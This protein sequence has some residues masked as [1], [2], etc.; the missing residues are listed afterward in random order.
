MCD[1]R[2]S[3][4]IE[5][6]WVFLWPT[7]KLEKCRKLKIQTTNSKALLTTQN[8]KNGL[9]SLWWGGGNLKNQWLKN[10]KEQTHEILTPL[11]STCQRCPY[12]LMGTR[13]CKQQRQ[14][15]H[16]QAGRILD[17]RW[18]VLEI[19]WGRKGP[20]KPLERSGKGSSSER[21]VHSTHPRSTTRAVG[22]SF[23]LPIVGDSPF[24]LLR[25]EGFLPF[26]SQGLEFPL[27]LPSIWVSP[28]HPFE[29]CGYFP[30][31][32]PKAVSHP[33]VLLR[34]GVSP[35]ILLRVKVPCFVLTR[36]GC[37]PLHPTKG[38]G[39]TPTFKDLKWTSCP[40]KGWGSHP[41]SCWWLWVSPFIFPRAR[42]TP[43]FSTENWGFPPFLFPKAGDFPL[44]SRGLVV[45]LWVLWRAGNLNAPE[46]L[47]SPISVL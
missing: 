20:S 23:I 4:Q 15:C 32:F 41:L 27:F 25:A 39:Y 29:G 38:K 36:V 34:L 47:Q 24:V 13:K 19:R 16:H 31:I 46:S 30:S 21:R 40:P 33:S 26:S 2:I 10:D 28:L 18:Q 17:C 45:P 11:A 42:D 7:Q 22:S 5:H 12:S 43:L 37:A 44:F 3:R 6:S 8:Q 9:T 14:H 1:T 35:S